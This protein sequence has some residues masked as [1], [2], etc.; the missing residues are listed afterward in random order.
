MVPEFGDVLRRFGEPQQ[1]AATCLTSV[2]LA[3]PVGNAALL[4]F[5]AEHIAV[6]LANEPRL[7]GP[8]TQASG[9]EPGNAVTVALA[10]GLGETQPGPGG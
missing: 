4:T 1:H 2:E 3:G 10:P 9:V 6:Q 7:L 8:P 5:A